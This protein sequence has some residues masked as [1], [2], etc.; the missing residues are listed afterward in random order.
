MR[1]FNVETAVGVFLVL[2]FL[3]FVWLAVRL[4]DVGFFREDE[5]TVV[6]RFGSVAGLSKGAVVEMAGVRIGQVSDIRL[7]PDYF[8]AVIR[9]TIQSDVRLPQ[10]SIASIRTTGIIGDRYVNI[11]PGGALEDIEPG[12]EIA[13]TE[14]AISL[15]ELIGRFIFD[16]E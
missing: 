5:Y 16:R 12:G 10:D 1:R 9:M 8:E 2:G 14:S 15:E 6:A 4:G 3:S 11:S 7:D 13:E